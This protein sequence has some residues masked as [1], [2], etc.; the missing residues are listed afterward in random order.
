[1]IEMLAAGL[2]GNQFSYEH[3]IERRSAPGGAMTFRNGQLFILIDPTR[4]GN[5]EYA[6][7]IAGFVEMMREGGMERIPGDRRY[8]TRERAMREGVPVTELMRELFAA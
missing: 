1:M 6:H 8:E 4:G 5:D 7:R 3:D 2:T